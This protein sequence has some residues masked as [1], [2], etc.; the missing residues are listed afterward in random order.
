MG[1]PRTT[2]LSAMV[3]DDGDVLS[4]LINAAYPETVPMYGDWLGFQ[5]EVW[6]Y[7]E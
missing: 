7:E 5:P 4:S 1:E 6:W 2:V 3:G